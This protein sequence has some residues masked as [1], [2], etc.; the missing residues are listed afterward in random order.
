MVSSKLTLS[1]IAHQVNRRL[2][3]SCPSQLTPRTLSRVATDHRP[4]V[5]VF[6]PGS[7]RMQPF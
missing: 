6:L 1:S 5:C 3:R 2:R 7:P 4:H